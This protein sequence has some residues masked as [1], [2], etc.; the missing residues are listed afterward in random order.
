MYI[1]VTAVKPLEDYTLWLRF[2]NG[3]EGVFDMSPYLDTGLFAQ[4]RDRTLFQSVQVCFDT[5]AWG[6][7]VDLC[8][9]TLYTQSVKPSPSSQTRQQV[10][11]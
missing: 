5:I 11:A 1:G 7:G 2:D 6:N 3:E 4:L 8:P 10:V 9:E